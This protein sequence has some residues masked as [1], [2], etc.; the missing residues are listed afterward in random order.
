MT[1]TAPTIRTHEVRPPSARAE[2]WMVA[3]AAF[4]IVYWS[5]LVVSAQT[6]DAGRPAAAASAPSPFERRFAELAPEDQRMYRAI[7]EGVAE[8]E[9]RRS[10]TGRWPS[11]DDLAREGVPPFAADPIDRARYTWSFVRTGTAVN[12]VGTPAAGADRE[13][14]AVIVVE[15]DPGTASDPTA[16]VDDVHHRLA[17][18][19][20]IHVTVWMGPP[21]GPLRD[22]VTVLA[23]DQGY[24]QVLTGR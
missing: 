1:T 24:K 4:H 2:T 17:E 3:R 18:G 5:A 23:P 8:A 22:A 21:L 7:Q 12:Y 20:M 11:A 13:T 14:F 16:Q 9:R 15:P 10:A 19:T 6:Y